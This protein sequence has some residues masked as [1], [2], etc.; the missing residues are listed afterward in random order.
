M[1]ETVV[2]FSEKEISSVTPK[3][4]ERVETRPFK[5]KKCRSSYNSKEE[6]QVHV[7]IDHVFWV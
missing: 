5:C 3:L 4:L 1:S 6:L 7:A 2:C